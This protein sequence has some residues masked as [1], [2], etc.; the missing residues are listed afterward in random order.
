M[1]RLIV[2]T[3]GPNRI[4]NISAPK[5]DLCIVTHDVVLHYLDFS[6]NDLGEEG[7]E[8]NFRE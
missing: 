6:A 2:C 7:L 5:S 3:L 8:A 4:P 1:S